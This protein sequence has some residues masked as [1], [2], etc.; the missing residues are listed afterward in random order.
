MD[1]IDIMVAEHENIKKMLEVIRNACLHILEGG[2]VNDEDFRN[3]IDFVRNYADKHHH[4]K[5]EQF[6]FA[7]MTEHL[8]GVG[9]NLVR[10]GMLV[11]HDLGR[12]HV[13]ALEKALDAY[14]R[15]PQTGHKLDILVHAGAYADLLTRHIEKENEVVYPYAKKNLTKGVLR[16]VDEW[17]RDF[18]NE[19][20]KEKVQESYLYLLNCLFDKYCTLPAHTV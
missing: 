7:Q 17:V 8:G 14:K 6:L 9:T 20:D 19:A 13:S 1:S 4:G 15:D 2:E 18:E 5:E 10:H 3:I 12:Y 11:E 16:T